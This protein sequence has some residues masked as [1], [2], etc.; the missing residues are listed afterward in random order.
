MAVAGTTG[1]GTSNRFF[2]F[3][4]TDDV[5]VANDLSRARWAYTFA[6]VTSLFFTWG[7]AYGVSPGSL[8]ASVR[9]S[10]DHCHLLAA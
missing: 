3:S 6:L 7:F 9:R 8:P 2:R 10:F 1:E 4:V 5:V